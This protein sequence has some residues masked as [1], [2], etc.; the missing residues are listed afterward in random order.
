VCEH[1]QV[2]QL[3]LEKGASPNLPNNIGETPLHFAV[4]SN[5]ETIV[6]LL[7]KYKADPNYLN[8][9]KFAPIHTAV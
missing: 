5:S 6:E 2:I 9:E 8:N 4:E 3:L 1:L 7:L